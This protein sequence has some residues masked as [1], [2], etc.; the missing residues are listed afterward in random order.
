MTK[1]PKLDLY[2]GHY[3]KIL[4]SFEERTHTKL[5][6]ELA[7]ASIGALSFLGR[8]D[9]ALT[10]YQIF[11]LKWPSSQR[12]EALFFLCVNFARTQNWK[13]ARQLFNNLRKL[14]R[15]TKTTHSLIHFFYYQAAMFLRNSKSQFESAKVFGNHAL[16]ISLR[17]NFLYGKILSADLLGHS[18][19]PTDNL[20]EGLKKLYEAATI[21]KSIKATGLHQ[22][23]LVSIT[24]YESQYGIHGAAESEIRLGKL[25]VDLKLEDSYSKINLYL[26]LS[27]TQTLAGSYL[28]ARQ[29]LQDAFQLIYRFNNPRQETIYKL[30]LAEL[31]YRRGDPHEALERI[32]DIK[33]WNGLEKNPS[34]VAQTLGLELKLVQNLGF[35]EKT[36]ELSAR[37]RSLKGSYPSK[38]HQ[39][40]IS[41]GTQKN[42]PPSSDVVGQL[43]ESRAS[44]KGILSSGYYGL[45]PSYLGLKPGAETLIWGLLGNSLTIVAN[46]GVQHIS[47]LQSQKTQQILQALTKGPTT[48]E[49]LVKSL[50]GYYYHPLRHDSILYAAIANARKTL[51][52]VAHWIENHDN[53]Y[54][55]KRSVKTLYASDQSAPIPADSMTSDTAIPR[56]LNHRQILFLRKLRPNLYISIKNYQNEFNVARNTATR[57]LRDLEQKHLVAAIGKGPARRYTKFKKHDNSA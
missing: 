32:L 53:T 18:L 34:L 13:T 9:E 50:W 40:I 23:I 45:L 41:R 36:S 10:V 49:N 56:S 19:I 30:R 37:L 12:A 55:L 47:K 43:L 15:D 1:S 51:G 46:E 35:Q 4:K 8:C 2:R 54:L 5:S 28:K 6:T 52:D 22:A 3:Q 17:A 11:A 38:L 31:A 27:R 25:I 29:T 39:R 24:L 20:H 48:K 57:D 14:S 42:F 33:R 44:P 7:V 26:E 16:E 21:A